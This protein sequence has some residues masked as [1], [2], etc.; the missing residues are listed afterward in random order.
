MKKHHSHTLKVA[1]FFVI[2]M[3]VTAAYLVYMYDTTKIPIAV[4][5][6]D[7]AGFN[8][9]TKN[10]NFGTV[11]PGAVSE[12]EVAIETDKDVF[13]TLSV[14]GIKFVEPLENNFMLKAGERKNIVVRASILGGEPFGNYTGSLVVVSKR[15]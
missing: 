11:Y 10:L 14:D 3:A 8:I 6:G 4:M 13:V 5:V 2:L 1:V 15:I 12:R 9:D 7:Y